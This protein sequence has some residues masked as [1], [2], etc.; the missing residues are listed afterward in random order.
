ML[1]ELPI[2]LFVSIIEYLEDDD[3]LT[4]LTLSRPLNQ[5]LIDNEFWRQRGQTKYRLSTDF[6]L[7]TS[8]NNHKSRYFKMKALINCFMINDSYDS[9]Y[10]KQLASILKQQKDLSNFLTN[11]DKFL[12]RWYTLIIEI[13]SKRC[14]IDYGTE[15]L[16]VMPIPLV[17]DKNFNSTALTLVI[18]QLFRY[19][20]YH[21]N[22]IIGSNIEFFINNLICPTGFEAAILTTRLIKCYREIKDKMSSSIILHKCCLHRVSLLPNK[23]I[24]TRTIIDQFVLDSFSPN[25]IFACIPDLLTMLSIK[26]KQFIIDGILTAYYP[27]LTHRNERFLVT[28]ISNLTS[29]IDINILGSLITLHAGLLSE[30]SVL[31]RI[32][33]EYVNKFPDAMTP[34]NLNKIQE[35]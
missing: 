3:L 7:L 31:K 15:P 25:E 35:L 17:M 1:L 9:V 10:I 11:N 6:N 23:G 33:I 5:L 8:N 21:G 30:N 14:L 26:K 29:T 16:S 12:Q 19:L 27:G 4:I 24:E 18:K 22:G 13:I 2:E 28:T 32:V 34:E 20:E